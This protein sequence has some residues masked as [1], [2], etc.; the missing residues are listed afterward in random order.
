MQPEG[1]LYNIKLHLSPEIALSVTHIQW[2]S[3]QAVTLNNDG[4]AI[5]QFRVDGLNDVSGWILSYGDRVKVLA[6]Q[7]LQAK[8][9]QIASRTAKLY[10]QSHEKGVQELVA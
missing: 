4:S 8:V 10:E 2:H 5:M 9:A 1:K 6:P 3:T 7:V